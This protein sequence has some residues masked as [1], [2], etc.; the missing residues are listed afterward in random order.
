MATCRFGNKPIGVGLVQRRL[1]GPGM[2][3]KALSVHVILES[4]MCAC[5]YCINMQLMQVS[6]V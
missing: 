4:N 1:H 6:L 2:Y 5:G 3:G